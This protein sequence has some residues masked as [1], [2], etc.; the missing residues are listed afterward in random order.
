MGPAVS[1]SE[2]TQR[3]GQA[4]T[5]PSAQPRQAPVLWLS[6]RAHARL[7][8]VATAGAMIIAGGSVAAIDGASPFAHGA[9]LT[10]YLV[11]VGGVAQLLLGI[12]SLAL[13]QPTGSVA[14]KRAQVG[15]WNAG[16]LAVA[17]GVLSDL[18]GLVVAG[19]AVVAAALACFARDGGPV[20]EPGRTRVLV[21]RLLI[22]A[23]LVSILVGGVLTRTS[24]GG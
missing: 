4:T 14:L 1:A 8:F 20:R 18:F 19:S 23:L 6:A 12:G 3:R 21:Y 10:A 7:V 15:L 2:S 11:L 17:A 22:C 5:L 13:P 16:T 24:P 9:W